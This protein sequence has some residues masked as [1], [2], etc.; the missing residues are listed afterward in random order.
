MGLCTCAYR[1]CVNVVFM[2]MAKGE[3]ERWRNGSTEGKETHRA[4]G[5][6]K[7]RYRE[8]EGVKEARRRETSDRGQRQRAR[9]EREAREKERLRGA[10]SSSFLVLRNALP[11]LPGGSVA[12]ASLSQCRGPRFNP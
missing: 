3:A 5:L 10:K 2:R 6:G 12:K 7:H 1:V 11:G 8:S 4:M 9:A